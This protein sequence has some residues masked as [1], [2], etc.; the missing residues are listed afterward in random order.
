LVKRIL[1]RIILISALL[2]LAGTSCLPAFAYDQNETH[3]ALTK[4]MAEFFNIQRGNALSQ[5]DIEALVQ[6]SIDED[7]PFRFINHFY[8]PTT[9]KGIS[10]AWE[11][12]VPTQMSAKEWAQNPFA[13]AGILHYTAQVMDV[14]A[15]QTWQRALYE[16]AKGNRPAAMYALGH[17]L[18][19]IADMTVPEHVRNDSHLGGPDTKSPLEDWAKG[20]ILQEAIRSVL[21]KPAEIPRFN[22]LNEAFDQTA[23]YTNK[24]FFSVGTVGKD[25]DLPKP[26]RYG[27][28]GDWIIAYGID[29]TSQTVYRLAA[30]KLIENEDYRLNKEISAAIFP[31]GFLIDHNAVK[32]DYWSFLS[33]KSI[34]NGA[35]VIDLFFREAE[36]LKQLSDIDPRMLAEMNS[37]AADYN[38]KKLANTI[39]SYILALVAPGKRITSQVA[40]LPSPLLNPTPNP[41][42]TP[43][44]RIGVLSSPSPLPRPSPRVEITSTPSP[45]PSPLS[46]SFFDVFISP[47]PASQKENVSSGNSTPTV[48]RSSAGDGPR[49]FSIEPTPSPT[50]EISPTPTPSLTSTPPPT[51]AGGNNVA[52]EVI[53]TLNPY[54]HME[55]AFFPI[56]T[57]DKLRMQDLPSDIS[58]EFKGTASASG[59]C[60]VSSPIQVEFFWFSYTKQDPQA[61]L[62]VSYSYATSGEIIYLSNDE[63]GVPLIFKINKQANIYQSYL[64]AKNVCLENSTVFAS[65]EDNNLILGFRIH[66]LGTTLD[67]WGQTSDQVGWYQ[68]FGFGLPFLPKNGL[69]Y[70]Q[71]SI[72][73][74]EKID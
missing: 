30:A 64:S 65:C 62:P 53:G 39:F 56:T 31:V 37:S 6:G 13:Q 1:A 29:E 20:E 41:T 54:Y 22:S 14:S 21:S 58:F 48:N 24:N 61:L 25:Y 7:K 2:L 23:G 44:P 68:K 32:S 16:Y 40:V 67:L 63:H 55:Q 45:R 66:S 9:G 28:E 49:Y 70:Y 34:L 19:L 50:P 43:T 51:F 74:L 12:Y 3:P 5:S 35:G 69:P 10:K 36:E 57:A 71:F 60:P 72:T 27:R 33:K 26:I 46:E 15:N 4:A 8:D 42:P 52:A 17:I 73:N 18:H 11:I 47:T 38:I 59:C